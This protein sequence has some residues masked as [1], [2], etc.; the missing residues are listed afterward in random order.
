MLLNDKFFELQRREHIRNP[1]SKPDYLL[2]KLKSH[3][4]DKLDAKMTSKKEGYLLSIAK[5]CHGKQITEVAFYLRHKILQLDK[6]QFSS[7]LTDDDLVENR[8]DTPEEL[9]HFYKVF[10]TG[11]E[12][13]V[14]VSEKE[15]RYQ[16]L[17]MMTYTRP[18]RVE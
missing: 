5:R 8:A 15:D 3:F 13:D 12:D 16:I 4:G 6:T 14:G 2:E 7:K 9:L 10:Y 17:Q 18:P 1:S 11:A